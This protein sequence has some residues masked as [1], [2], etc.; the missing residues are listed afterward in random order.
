M[1][2]FVMSDIHGDYLAMMEGLKKA[3]YDCTNLNHQ[4]IVIGDYF[5][6]ATTSEGAYGVFKYLTSDEHKNNSPYWLIKIR[7][8]CKISQW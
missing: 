5:G 3:E 8:S 2:L 4:L 6:R 1:K 7:F